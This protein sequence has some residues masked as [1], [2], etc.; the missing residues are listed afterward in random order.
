MAHLKAFYCSVVGAGLAVVL[1][2]CTTTPQAKSASAPKKALVVTVTTGFRHDSIKTAEETIAKLGEQS[3]AYTVEYVHQPPNEPS[4]PNKPNAPKAPKADSD[5]EKQKAAQE[6]YDKEKEKYEADLAKYLA[7][8][9]KLKADYEKAKAEWDQK[10]KEALRKLSPLSLRNYDIVIFANTTGDL[11]LPD[12][13][14]FIDWVRQGHAF[15]ATHSGSDTFHGYRPYIDMLGGEFQTHGAQEKVDCI[16]ADQNHPAT[17]HF[18]TH[19]N[20]GDRQE[21]IYIIKS[22]N[23]KTVHELLYLDKHPNTKEPGHYAVSWCKQ[24]GKG[25]VFYTSLG[26]NKFV[27][28]RDDYQKHVL[29]G[30]KWALGLEPGDATPQAK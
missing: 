9:P 30:I 26:H 11:P 10:V 14:G 13:N 20:I 17:K 3:G 12:P 21:E 6:K 29:G 22:Y 19:Y 27:W 2:G 16:V 1:S 4:Q 28:E 24:F 5:P 7:D 23:P 18:G 15:V 25:K 8:E